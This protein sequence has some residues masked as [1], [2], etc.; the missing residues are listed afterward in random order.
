MEMIVEIFTTSRI[1]K[2][3]SGQGTASSSLSDEVL[4]D[5]ETTLLEKV[6][7][8]RGNVSCVQYNL[9]FHKDSLTD[10]LSIQICN[11]EGDHEQQRIGPL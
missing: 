8:V 2:G 5:V 10:E 6:S 4:L 1:H 11:Q 7:V 3:I 9:T